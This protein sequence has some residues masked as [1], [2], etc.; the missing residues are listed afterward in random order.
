MAL[1]ILTLTTLSCA[2][3][4]RTQA[5]PAIPGSVE[6][7]NAQ[8]PPEEPELTST[9]IDERARAITT[10]CNLNGIADA[11]DLAQGFDDDVN[12]NGS[13]DFCDPDS[14]L[15]RQARTDEAWR[16]LAATL[17]SSFFSARLRYRQGRNGVL[18]RYTVPG[19]TKT[20]SLNVRDLGTSGFDTTLVDKA[21][22]SG[23]LELFWDRRIRGRNA[24][25]SVYEFRLRVGPRAY[26][27]RLAWVQ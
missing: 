16:G 4:H 3:A 15:R 20:V 25:P 27:R 22:E 17:D 26:S 24:P 7:S 5:P 2:D 18:L 6:P 8:G 12:H 9:E 23:A 19:D 11:D 21:R 13:I 14:A 10:D 1:A